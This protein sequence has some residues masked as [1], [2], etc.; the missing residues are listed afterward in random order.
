MVA[1][2][3]DD[4]G[5]FFFQFFENDADEARVRFLPTAA[6]LK[7][8][9]VDDVAV[10]NEFLA[11]HV[12]E[13]VIY[14]DR[15]ALGGAEMDIRDDN[16]TDTELAHGFESVRRAEAEPRKTRR[17][18]SAGPGAERG[19]RSWERTALPTRR[20]RGGGRAGSM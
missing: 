15:L 11:A 13:E 2:H 18:R 3:V 14:L 9:A 6:A 1:A 12:T 8:P 4:F 10:E 5:V 20:A 16:G 7:L 17:A 19:P